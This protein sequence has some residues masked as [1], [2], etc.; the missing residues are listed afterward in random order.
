M[1]TRTIPRGR[2]AYVLPAAA[3][4]A[5]ALAALATIGFVA[6]AGTAAPAEPP[7]NTDR[8]TISDTTPQVGQT[9]TASAGTWTGTQPIRFAYRW[10]RCNAGGQQCAN[11]PEATA[12][13]Y[14]V[15]AS[16]LGNT[17]RVRVTA[18]N[19]AGSASADSAATSRVR[20]APPPAP[21]GTVIPVTAVVPPDRLI[22]D[23][24]TFTPN[25]VVSATQ[26]ITVR[27]R[28]GDTRGRLV[29]GA[30]VFLRSTP[31]VTT[32]PPEQATGA[33]GSVTLTTTPRPGFRIL[34]RPGYNLQFFV[35]ARKPGESLLAGVSS[36]RL[37]QVRLSPGR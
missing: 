37:V 15:R 30:L 4:A 35:R 21:P 36:R 11:I 26:P 29:S 18:T 20:A 31:L 10:R 16:D 8:P 32:A 5:L 14:I 24:V 25:P 6:S 28:V 23:Q 7:R 17:L 2:R 27:V 33:D 34:F 9:L 19:S 3:A 22:V 13:T 12:Q 1:A